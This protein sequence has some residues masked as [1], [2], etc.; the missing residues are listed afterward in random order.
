MTVKDRINQLTDQICN[1]TGN[2]HNRE[3]KQRIKELLMT[4]TADLTVDMASALIA[5]HLQESRAGTR[6]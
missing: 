3:T 2:G 5:W 4:Y 1:L 6:N